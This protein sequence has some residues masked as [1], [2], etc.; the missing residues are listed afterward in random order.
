MKGDITMA[1]TIKKTTKLATDKP[2]KLSK[3]GEYFKVGK[4]FLE[5]VRFDMRLVLK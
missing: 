3:I 1:T 2:K 4:P 5:G